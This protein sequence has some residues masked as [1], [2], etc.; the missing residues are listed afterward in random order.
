MEKKRI[1]T[2]AVVFVPNQIRPTTENTQ[3]HRQEQYIKTQHK[4]G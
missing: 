2:L 3:H 4:N 1:T